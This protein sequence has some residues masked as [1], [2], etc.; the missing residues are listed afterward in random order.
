MKGLML[1]YVAVPLVVSCSADQ[2]FRS[3]DFETDAEF[4]LVVDE[5]EY[6]RCGSTKI[7]ASGAYVTLAHGLTPG[8]SDGLEVIFFDSRVV[9]SEMDDLLRDD[10]EA[11]RR[12]G[13]YAALVLF[14]DEDFQVLQA[15]L[16]YVVPGTTVA[17]T[18]A[19]NANE[20]EQYF[21]DMSYEDGRLR[22]RSNGAYS[23]NT[24]SEVFTLSWNIDVDL[25]VMR[26]V[27][28]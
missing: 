27:Q 22:L 1:A 25:P 11:K 16:S 8:N 26:E 6:L 12:S 23:E 21:S 19:S 13:S 20:L 14:V 28:R 17:Y 3:G 5:S 7:D 10:A 2:G 4:E 9:E 15:N 18:I 24:S